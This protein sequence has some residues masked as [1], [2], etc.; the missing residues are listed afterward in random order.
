MASACGPSG[1]VIALESSGTVKA[2][3]HSTVDVVFKGLSH[4]AWP[5]GVKHVATHDCPPFSSDESRL[6]V[7][8]TVIGRESIPLSAY[9][10]RINQ[11]IT[12]SSEQPLFTIP[13]SS[14]PAL[15]S[16]PWLPWS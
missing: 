3:E 10:S 16:D 4:H 15:V 8:L 9:P 5:F 1:F 11:G 7:L 2:Q 14:C 6:L 12:A 13:I